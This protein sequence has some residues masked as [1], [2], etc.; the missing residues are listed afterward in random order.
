MRPKIFHYLQQDDFGGGPRTIEIITQHYNRIAE[1]HV[2]FAGEAHL[3]NLCAA[4][5]GLKRHRLVRPK[6]W[7]LPLHIVSLIALLWKVRPDVVITHGQRSGAFMGLALFFGPPCASIYVVHFLGVY[8]IANPLIA[9]RNVTAERLAFRLHR[10]VVCLS[11]SSIRQCLASGLAK[12]RDQLRLIPNPITVQIADTNQSRS[13][14]KTSQTNRTVTFLFMGRLEEQKRP[15]W[16][17]A[18][19]RA[20]LDMGL[21]NSRLLI[22]GDGSLRDQT[23][24]LVRRLGLESTVQLIG[25][26]AR[27]EDYLAS[28]DVVLLT[29]M[30]E[31]F[32]NVAVEAMAAGKPIIA[33]AADGIVDTVTEETGYLIPLGAID[34]MAAKICELA[35]NPNRRKEMGEKGRRRANQFSI[36]TNKVAYRNLLSEALATRIRFTTRNMIGTAEYLGNDTFVP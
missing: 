11:E 25:Y 9:A 31:T 33:N 26:V 27:P 34:L 6:L 12:T 14:D 17:L 15:D 32:G 13:L 36:A 4:N 23:I 28:C 29:T 20:A 1:Q 2:A 18:A 10:F 8:L 24:A 35:T 19:W 5:A 7:L 30:F 3:A 16:L 21:P 22:L